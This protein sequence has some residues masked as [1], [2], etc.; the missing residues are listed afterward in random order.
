[1]M[2]ILGLGLGIS[3]Y[4]LRASKGTLRAVAIARFTTVAPVIVDGDTIRIDGM[5]IRIIG[6]DAPDS[7]PLRRHSGH[8]LRRL[9]SR[10]G[11]M[12][13][14]VDL[15]ARLTTGSRCRAPAT[16]YGRA[17]MSCVFNRN[18]ADV[19]ATM[20]AHGQAVDYRVFSDGAYRRRMVGAAIA[21]QGLWGTHYPV[22]AAL[23]DRRAMVNE[24]RCQR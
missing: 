19:A 2:L 20:V 3:G 24:R 14:S 6:I 17:D 1:M 23:A 12:T 5:P 13:C 18:S 10:D 21:R 4:A 16:S 9:A 15:F 7:E 11:G 22:M 8:H